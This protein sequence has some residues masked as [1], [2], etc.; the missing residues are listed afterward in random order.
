MLYSGVEKSSLSRLR[1]TC[2]R[3][4]IVHRFMKLLHVEGDGFFALVFLIVSCV[5]VLGSRVFVLYMFYT[6]F[7]L[8]RGVR[9][10]S[11]QYC[12]KEVLCYFGS[13]KDM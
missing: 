2:T 3:L 10:I 13:L 6:I 4:G 8:C 12:F 7:T 11:L 9:K 5:R 1:I